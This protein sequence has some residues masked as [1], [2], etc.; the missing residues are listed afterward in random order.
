MCKFHLSLVALTWV[1]TSATISSTSSAAGAQPMV[2]PSVNAPAASANESAT[3]EA[4]RRTQDSL[5][6]PAART[7]IL[8]GDAKGQA[9]DAKVRQLLGTN[10]EGA[11][12]LSSEVLEKIVIEAGGDAAKMQ[13]IVNQL[14]ANPQSLEKYMTPAQREEVRRMANDIEN[15][16]GSAPVSGSG[17]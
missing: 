9:Q 7:Q 15:K 12:K 5:T 17:R 1:L 6:N 2:T 11:Y 8:K 4:L 3:Q 14:M 16:R 13:A 10:T